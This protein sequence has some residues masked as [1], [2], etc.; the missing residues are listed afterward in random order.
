MKVA[1]HSVFILKENILFL[2]EWIQ[3]HILLGF[4]K[5]YLYDNSKVNKI[6]GWDLKTCSKEI[7]CGKRN[8]HNVD[9]DKIVTMTNDQMNNFVIELCK[10]YPCVDIIEWSPTDKD[11]NVL[12]GQVEA[13]N[14]CLNRL[15]K[16]QVNWCAS[17][18]MDEYIVLKKH[19]S[20]IDYI[21]SLQSNIK[22]IEMSQTMFDSRFNN[23]DK[24]VTDIYK[25]YNNTQW[26]KKNIF[27]VASTINV[28]VHSVVVTGIN[29]KPPKRD[30]MFNHYRLMY[31][32]YKYNIDNINKGIRTKLK[33]H[34]F[35]PVS[36]NKDY[37]KYLTL[38]NYK[39]KGKGKGKILMKL[40]KKLNL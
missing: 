8:K 2:E 17:I 9:Y 11:G 29:Y 16:D 39:D 31:F 32:N 14:H 3:Y 27:N 38:I 4:S 15:R 40:R 23:I 18:D 21:S 19:N 28:N 25:T 36:Y 1:I 35:I 33:T 22:N 6:T 5:F 13:H 12:Y 37:K 10:K 30:I 26:E 34:T 7:I 20:I 24:L